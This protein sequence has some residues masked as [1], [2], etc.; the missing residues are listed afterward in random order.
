MALRLIESA[1][2]QLKTLETEALNYQNSPGIALEQ[3]GLFRPVPDRKLD[4]RRFIAGYD[5]A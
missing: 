3:N 2:A 5:P 1:M 4:V